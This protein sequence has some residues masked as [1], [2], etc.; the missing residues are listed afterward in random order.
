VNATVGPTSGLPP[1]FLAD[2]NLEN[3]IIIGLRQKRPGMTILTAH[4]AGVI[5]L[6]DPELLQRAKEL[7]LILITHDRKT[8]YDHFADFLMRL[9]PGEHSPGVLLVSQTKHSIG[10][11]ISFILEVYDLSRHEEWRDLPTSLPL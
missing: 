7:D 3:A 5:G 8:M 1:R 11:I 6:K 9:S 2:E 4:E 10:Q